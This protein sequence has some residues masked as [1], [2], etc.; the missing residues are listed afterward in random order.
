M[1]VVPADDVGSLE[2]K[3]RLEDGEFAWDDV[4]DAEQAVFGCE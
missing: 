1:Q 4:A 3:V 2:L